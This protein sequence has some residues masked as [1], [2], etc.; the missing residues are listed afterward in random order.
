M[1]HRYGQHPATSPDRYGQNRRYFLDSSNEKKTIISG[2][3]EFCLV[4]PSGYGRLAAAK[5]IWNKQIG[6]GAFAVSTPPSLFDLHADHAIITLRR[7][8]ASEHSACATQV[9]P[10]PGN[11]PRSIQMKS[12]CNFTC[13]FLK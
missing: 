6:R 7:V 13:Y 3:D 2:K 4:F 5:T 12:S 10:A 11:K 9:R 8:G 1:P